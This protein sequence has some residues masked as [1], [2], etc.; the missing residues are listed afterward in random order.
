MVIDRD[1]YVL[2]ADAARSPLTVA[3]DPVPDAVDTAQRLDIE[4]DEIA[5]RRLSGAL[6]RNRHRR[7][8]AM[9]VKPPQPGAPGSRGR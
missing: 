2:P 3:V 7:R 9:E 8:W 5:R 6:H 1:V 4:V